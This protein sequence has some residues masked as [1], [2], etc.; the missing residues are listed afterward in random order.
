MIKLGIKEIKVTLKDDNILEISTF[1]VTKS[2][3]P[4]DVPIFYYN[5]GDTYFSRD[6]QN[7]DDCVYVDIITLKVYDLFVHDVIIEIFVETKVI[8]LAEW[9]HI[10]DDDDIKYPDIGVWVMI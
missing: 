3:N 7:I 1:V 9:I 10:N 4:E 2:N 5:I 6:G 8:N